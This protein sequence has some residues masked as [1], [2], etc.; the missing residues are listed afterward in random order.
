MTPTQGAAL[1]FDIDGTLADTDPLH[2]AAFNQAFAPYGQQFDKPRFARELQGLANVDIARRLLPQLSPEA[3]M[4][5][6]DAKEAMFR[7]L[8]A[9]AIEPVP[10]LFALLDW[11]DAHGVPMAAVTNAPRANAEL[12]LGGLG[13]T[14]RFGAVV[15]GA[16]LP[17]SK[18]HP[19]PYLEGL[20]LLGA[21]AEVSVGF[22][23]SRTGITAAVAAGLST[24][25]MMTSLDEAALLAAGASLATHRYDDPGVMALITA[26]LTS[27]RIA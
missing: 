25:G 4:A 17:H 19:L 3:G 22:E 26:R 16:E 21:N 14:K 2:L 10:G 20:R 27:R 5:V 18:P 12:V 9:S 24:V 23:D 15:I 13:I 7:E 6:L 11:A 8:A 1:L